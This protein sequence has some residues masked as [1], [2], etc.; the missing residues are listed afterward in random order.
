MHRSLLL[1][2]GSALSMFATVAHAQEASAPQQEIIVTGTQIQ[3]SDYQPSSPVDIVGRED[4]EAKAPATIAEFVKDLPYNTGSSF[5]SGRAFGNERGA[6][7]INL[8]GLGPSATLV[9]INGRRQTQLPDAEDAIVDVN[10]LVPEIMLERVEI[11]KDGASATYGSDAVAGVV[12]FITNDNFEGLKVSGRVNSFTYSD[13]I[14]YRLEG[15]FGTDLGSS[16]HVTAAFGYY[17]QDPINGY[18]FTTPS[19]KNTINDPRFSSAS[20]SPGEFV[21]PR[22]NANGV[23]S[24]APLANIVDPYCGTMPSSVASSGGFNIVD[25]PADARD[26]R[27]QFWG[28]NGSQSEIERYQGMMRGYTDISDSVRFDAEF[29]FAHVTSAT[30]YTAGDTLGLSP[31]IPGH[32]PGNIFR[33]KDANGNP[34]YAVSSGVSAGYVRDGSEVFLPARDSN[35]AVILT[36]DPTNPASGIP[37]YEDVIFSGRPVNSQCNL[38]TGGSMGP[39]ECAWSRPSKAKNTILRA[40]GGLSGNLGEAWNWRTGVSWSRY[41][42]STNGTVGVALV[43]ELNYALQGL[44]GPNC[45]R[46][47][48]TPGRNGCEYFN[49]FGNSAYANPGDPQ[50]NSQTVID[51]VLPLLKDEYESQLITADAVVSGTLFT[52]PAGPVDIAVGYQ[53]REERLAADYDTQANL[54]NKA[55][56]VTQLDFAASRGTHSIFAEAIVPLVDS[57]FG[58]LEATGAIRHEWIGDNLKTTNPKIGLLYHTQDDVL[59]LR[60]SYGTSF[61]APSLFRLYASSAR[62]A[63]VNDCPISQHPACTGENN[64]R[65]A[66]IQQ[67]NLNLKPETSEAWSFG[68]IVQPLRGLRFEATWWNFTFKDKI[69]T[70]TATAIVAANPTGTPENP[71]VRAPDGRLLSVTTRFFNQSAVEVEGIDFSVDYTTEFFNLGTINFNAGG[72]KLLTYNVQDSPTSPV[73][74]AKGV[75]YDRSVAIATPNT[76]F[77]LNARVSWLYEGHNLSAAVRY[78]APIDF[79]NDPATGTVLAEIDAW[80][81]IDVSYTYTFNVGSREIQLGVGAQNVFAMEEPQVPAPGFQPFIPILHDTRGRSVY[82]KASITF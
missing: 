59:T 69:A 19:Q 23:I 32:N 13:A 72:M 61:I 44:G 82:A 52:L 54:G 66:Q 55:N 6:G 5:A 48:Y 43:N 65:I 24:G 15:M 17:Y 37:F 74:D 62:G 36:G 78:Y 21:V 29:G 47:Q 80:Y 58:Y 28:D 8:R 11:L 41:D 42:L 63:G 34:L 67:G 38:P 40:A 50:A 31:V 49:L 10:S 25:N 12:N 60:G 30:A 53:F 77:R 56:G 75:F 3:R 22:R 76:D 35:G 81:P 18:A 46:S 45:N 68:G 9:L 39:G 26:C 27:Y 1:V 33:A 57:S 71:V 16:G 20:S 2:G 7:T 73:I 70:E 64:V 51:Y 14:D 4:L 79:S